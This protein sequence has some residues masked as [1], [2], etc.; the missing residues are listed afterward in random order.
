[1]LNQHP[2]TAVA[3]PRLVRRIGYAYVVG[4]IDC[5]GTLVS[6]TYLLNHDILYVVKSST[7]AFC[8]RN[9]DEEYT[10]VMIMLLMFL[11]V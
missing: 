4:L 6:D 3:L 1:M 7:E 8:M 5:L 10:Y 9:K 2:K 11:L